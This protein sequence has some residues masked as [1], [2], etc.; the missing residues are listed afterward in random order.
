MKKKILAIAL[1]LVLCFE[2]TGCSSQQSTVELTECSSQQSTVELTENDINNYIDLV[3]ICERYT[4]VLG[5]AAVVYD[6]NTGVMYLIKMSGYQFGIS[7]IYNSD[8]T[9]KLYN[10]E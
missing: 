8:G 6:R 9:I 1:S 2:L 5:L 4:S 3:V 7:P 10:G